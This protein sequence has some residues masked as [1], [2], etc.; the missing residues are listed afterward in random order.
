MFS[1]QPKI[2]PHPKFTTKL[3]RF[4]LNSGCNLKN[5]FKKVPDSLSSKIQTAIPPILSALQRVQAVC[6]DDTD[7][8]EI[9]ENFLSEDGNLIGTDYN[10]LLETDFYND[11]NVNDDDLQNRSD[12]IQQVLQQH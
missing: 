9:P 12:S 11:D 7:S 5:Q 8:I 6:G 3:T 10:D 4:V 1:R 2:F